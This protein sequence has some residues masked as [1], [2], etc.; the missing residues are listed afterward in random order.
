MPVGCPHTIRSLAR[1]VVKDEDW[2]DSPCAR[3]LE[4]SEEDVVVM[5]SEVRGPHPPQRDRHVVARGLSE[6]WG[7]LR[8]TYHFHGPGN[9]RS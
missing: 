3:K 7:E 2:D 1:T 4:C 9:V 5:N 8:H 6:L